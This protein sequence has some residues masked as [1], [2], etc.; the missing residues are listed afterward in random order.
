MDVCTSQ[1]TVYQD[2]RILV[3]QVTD[4]STTLISPKLEHLNALNSI[5]L[6]PSEI[7]RAFL[8]YPRHGPDGSWCSPS[9][10]MQTKRCEQAVGWLSLEHPRLRHVLMV[11]ARMKKGSED[12]LGSFIADGCVHLVCCGACELVKFAEVRDLD[13]TLPHVISMSTERLFL[14]LDYDEIVLAWVGDD[15][16][17]ECS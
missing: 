4:T 7:W 12:S 15:G 16:E 9:S 1:V 8:Q 17:F 11:I 10:P 5:T 14:N 2:T 6:P 13:F 3:H